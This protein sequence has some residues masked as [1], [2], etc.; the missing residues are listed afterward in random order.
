[1]EAAPPATPAP[2]VTVVALGLVA[3][4]LVL[5][6]IS[7]LLDFV[8]GNHRTWTHDLRYVGA[9]ALVLGVALFVAVLGSPLPVE[10]TVAGMASA[11]T[12]SSFYFGAIV[13]VGILDQ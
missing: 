10:P 12:G 1:M 4:A 8:T 6:S 5:G 3:I 9:L 7:P 11:V 2:E 13:H